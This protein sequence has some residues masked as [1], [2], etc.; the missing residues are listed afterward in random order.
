MQQ[1]FQQLITTEPSD[2]RALEI[3]LQLI[4]LI[5]VVVLVAI[6]IGIIPFWFIFKKAGVPGW[7]ALIPFYNTYTLY[8]IV[9]K[10]DFFW[11][12]L[13]LSVSSFLPFFGILA[14]MAGFVISIIST[15]HLARVFKKSDGF[16]VGL[17][18][19][20]LIF[21]YILAFDKSKYHPELKNA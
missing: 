10:T 16:T 2:E 19:L 7:K 9:W 13:A 20:P 1:I 15:I 5:I 21:H 8:E 14:S 6:I 17:I 12:S 3:I 4:P 18:F 11:I